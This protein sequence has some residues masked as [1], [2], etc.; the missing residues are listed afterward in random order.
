MT[1]KLVL[2][3][4]E[5]ACSII[6]TYENT[7]KRLGITTDDVQFNCRKICVA[8]NIQDAWI[9]FYQAKA[10]E[11]NPNLADSDITMSINMLL[12]CFGAKELLIN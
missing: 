5:Y 6:Q 11:E 12:L 8:E 10:K 9:K 7:A 1:T 4:D 3:T 2:R